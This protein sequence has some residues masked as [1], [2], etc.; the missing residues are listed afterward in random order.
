MEEEKKHYGFVFYES[1]YEEA[2][3][4]P[5]E[6]KVLLYEAICEYGFY[7]KL[8]S[9]TGSLDIAFCLIKPQIAKSKKR[10]KKCIENGKM[11]GRPVKKNLLLN[12]ENSLVY[13]KEMQ[14]RIDDFRALLNQE[15]SLDNQKVSNDDEDSNNLTNNQENFSCNLTDKD[16][17]KEKD[18]EKDKTTS[19]TSSSSSEVDSIIEKQ[20]NKFR[21]YVRDETG[22]EYI[23]K[24][25]DYFILS[26]KLRESNKEI[27][28][29]KIAFLYLACKRDENNLRDFTVENLDLNWDRLTHGMIVKTN[30]AFKGSNNDES[31]FK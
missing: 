10:Y 21:D 11:G 7:G 9:F 4:L 17:E 3:K 5:N 1:F 12:Q 23:E 15:N 8:P 13:Q 22:H 26:N 16:K 14:Q 28:S 19:S 25:N 30:N 18:K 2:R 6:E 31:N 29:N 20:L 27:L 24:E